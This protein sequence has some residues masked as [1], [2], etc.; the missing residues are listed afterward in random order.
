MRLFIGL[1]LPKEIKDEL[2]A[3]QK[4]IPNNLAKINWVAKKR[5]HLTMKFL[6]N[7][8]RDKLKEIEDILR[9]I[10]F[11]PFNVNLTKFGFFPNVGNPKILWTSLFP[12]KKIIKLQQKIDGE[13]LSLFKSDQKFNPHLTLGRIKFIKKKKEFL[14]CLKKIRIEPK[15]FTIKN[16]YLIESKLT[17]EGPCYSILSEFNT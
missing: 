15:I 12:E 5:L 9:N 14:D 11:K 16:F 2:F 8:D 1:V 7:V 3:V 10:K 13:L 17:R 4:N 6:G